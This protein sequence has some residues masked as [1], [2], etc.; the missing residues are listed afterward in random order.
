[1]NTALAKKPLPT[2]IVAVEQN[3]LP[4]NGTQE[5][6]LEIGT[7]LDAAPAYAVITNQEQLTKAIECLARLRAGA[8]AWEKKRAYMKAPSLEAGRRVDEQFKPHGDEMA[9][10]IA[11]VNK[12]VTAYNLLEQQRLEA[13]ERVRR[14]A[15]QERLAAEAAE[16]RKQEQAQREEAA[17][18]EREAQAKL[19][20]AAALE[21]KGDQKGSQAALEAASEAESQAATASAQAD[22][23]A[24]EAAGLTQAA[25]SVAAAPLQ[26][27]V[28]SAG[29]LGSKGKLKPV[30]NYRITDIKLVPE[31]YLVAP[32]DRIEKSMVRAAM[33]ADKPIAGIEYFTEYT[34]STTASRV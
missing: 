34:T 10:A 27:Q 15:E 18:K 33:N 28:R 6:V 25:E 23:G 20:E 9:A 13:E 21:A 3:C 14:Q 12:G 26:V 30:K 32:E 11:S 17:R 4:E 31:Q 5:L 22:Q 1:M 24:Q 19:D 16:R 29:S 7:F 2:S 8:S